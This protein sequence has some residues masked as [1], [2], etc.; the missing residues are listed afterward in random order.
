MKKT[1]I[2]DGFYQYMF[3]PLFNQQFGF[4]IYV[5]Y[6]NFQNDVLMIDTGSEEQTKTVLNDLTSSNKKVRDV[7]ISHFHDD[8]IYGLKELSNPNVYG[9]KNYEL[10]LNKYTNKN[11]HRYFIPNKIIDNKSELLFGDFKINFLTSP[12]HSICNIFTI[13][14]D[15]Y[16]HISDDIMS[17]NDGKP[18]LPSVEYNSIIDHIKSLNLLKKYCGYT[19]LPSHGI[20]LKDS[21]VILNDIDNRINYLKNVS[22]NKNKIPYEEAILN[23]NCNFLHKEWHKDI[24]DS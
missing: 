20:L 3:P 7:I 18:I 13:I 1:K 17:N 21:T 11:D 16:I 12:G 5:L 14:N 9:N 4:N 15:K 10:T 23:C 6:D 24:Y 19:F 22:N 8:H 2:A